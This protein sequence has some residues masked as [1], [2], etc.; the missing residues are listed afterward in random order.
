MA[1]NFSEDRSCFSNQGEITAPGGDGYDCGNGC[2]PES[3]N[4]DCSCPW[5][6]VSDAERWKYGVIGP[7]FPNRA[8]PFGFA[9]WL[10]TSFAAPL[11]SGL[12]AL[13]LDKGKG[14][15]TPEDV[16]DTIQNNGRPAAGASLPE[17][18]INVPATLRNIP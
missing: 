17:K 18:I 15:L 3:E 4:T 13:V 12:A 1:S 6:K 5:N 11:V 7:V 10:G 14:R 8:F 9:R 16:R 2:E